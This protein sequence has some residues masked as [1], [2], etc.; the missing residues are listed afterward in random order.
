MYKCRPKYVN[1]LIKEYGS[2][3]CIVLSHAHMDHSGALPVLSREYPDSRIYT[4]HAT[5][6]LV[7]ILQ[8]DSLKSWSTFYSAGHIAGAVGVFLSGDEGSF[9]YSGDFSV[10]P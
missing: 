4:T 6:D 9:F 3:D 1:I 10:T 7:R 8:Y 5:K 2:V